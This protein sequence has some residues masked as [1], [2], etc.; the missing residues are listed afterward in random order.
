M[1]KTDDTFPPQAA[2]DRLTALRAKNAANRQAAAE[3]VALLTR[4]DAETQLA[5]WL[6]CRAREG[7]THLA[8]IAQYF[9][10]PGAAGIRLFDP[11][12]TDIDPAALEDVLICLCRDTL[13]RVMAEE[14]WRV[15]PQDRPGHEQVAAAKRRLDAEWLVLE[16]EEERLIRQMEAAGL[17][18]DRRGDADPA[19]VLADDAALVAT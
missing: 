7:R 17:T 1:K 6:D 2:R 12:G 5:D 16:R 4:P 19:T 15:I 11:P 13:E 10:H 3:S 18:A 8:R 14:L 9:Q